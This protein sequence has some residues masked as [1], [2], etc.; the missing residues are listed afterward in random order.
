MLDKLH[1]VSHI[2]MDS[3]TD[4]L[5]LTTISFQ[6]S[7]QN[8]VIAYKRTGPEKEIYTPRDCILEVKGAT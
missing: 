8:K 5:V 7:K 3:C 6:C 2:T 4:K 1:L